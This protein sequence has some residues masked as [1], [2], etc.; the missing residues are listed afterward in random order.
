M[1]DNIALSSLLLQR[2]QAEDTRANAHI[3][4]VFS[5]FL[6]YPQSLWV[7]LRSDYNSATLVPKLRGLKIRLRFN[8][9]LRLLE[10]AGAEILAAMLDA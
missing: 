1:Y 6:P 5:I 8:V 10:L 9:G 2:G 4:G 3:S 7:K